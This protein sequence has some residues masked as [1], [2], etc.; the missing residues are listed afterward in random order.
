[1][2][3]TVCVAV[4]TVETGIKHDYKHQRHIYFLVVALASNIH[5]H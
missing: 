3:L 5:L 2:F 4:D 1:M